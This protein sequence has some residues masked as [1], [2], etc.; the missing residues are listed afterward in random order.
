MESRFSDRRSGSTTNFLGRVRAAARK[1]ALTVGLVFVPGV[2]HGYTTVPT[3]PVIQDQSVEVFEASIPDL[4][5]AMANGRVTA[6]QLV[7][8]YV[9]R[10]DA[11]DQGGPA[12]NSMIRLNPNARARA[13]ALDQE[14]AL[15]GARGP[16]HGIP[17]IL[18]DNYDTADMPTSGGSIA[19]AGSIP[20]TTRSRSASYGRPEL[21]FW[22]NPTCTSLRWASRPSVR[23]EVRP[24]TRTIPPGTREAPAVGPARLLRPVLQPS[25]GAATPVGRFVFQRHTTTCSDSDRPRA[26]RAS[27][28]SSPCLTHR[29]WV[30][31]WPALR[32]TSPSGWTLP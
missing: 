6:V 13:A 24:V 31:L 2:A 17:I 27:T 7:D 23:S 28:G 14:R 5:E 20:P 10:I 19:L 26:S 30:D 32:W 16:L 4:Q 21:S 25:A 9:A 3:L 8:A 15:R 22:E 12:L 29:T 18:K 11:Y 1:A